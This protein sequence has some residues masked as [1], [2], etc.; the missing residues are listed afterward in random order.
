MIFRI[1]LGSAL[2]IF[3]A[4]LVYRFRSIPGAG[5]FVEKGRAFQEKAKFDL[6]VRGGLLNTVF[7]TKLFKAAKLRWLVHFLVVS[8]FVYLLVVHALD[9]VTS[10]LFY[11]YQPGI[12]PFRFL[13][14]LAG[15]F[16]GLG[17]ILFLLRRMNRFRPGNFHINRPGISASLLI[18]ALVGSGFLLESFQIISEP[19]FDEMVADYSELDEENGLMDLKGFWVQE[20]HLV[21]KDTTFKARVFESGSDLNQEYCMDCHDRPDSAFVSTSLAGFV[22]EGGNRLARFRVDKFLY[23]LHAGIALVLLALVP[24]TR[25][26]H[27]IAIPV[28]SSRKR[29]TPQSLEQGG[30]GLDFFSLTACT[31]CRFCSQV[32]NVYP[33]Y[34]ITGNAGILPHVKIEAIRTMAEKGIGDAGTAVLLRS[35]ND[36]CARCGRCGDIC[37]AGIDLVRLWESADSLMEHLGCPDNYTQVFDTP[38]DQ[39]T[40][41]TFPSQEPDTNTF[42]FG[43]ADQVE[44]FENCVQCTICTNACP[45]VAYD[46]D[47]TDLGPHQ[48]MNL[49]RLGKKE[50]ATASPM[51]W[52]CLTCYACQELCPQGIRITDILL[53]LRVQGQ[54]RAEQIKLTRLT[55]QGG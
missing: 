42:C 41:I 9:D 50:M 35:G 29:V 39:W 3:L 4:G 49:L 14:N 27:L 22:R 34:Q 13:R 7:Q 1:L 37:P 25:M 19:R 11:W 10:G 48:V 55:S 20:Y 38:L 17:C 8:G 26:F 6:D 52:N 28:A 2:I 16:V 51:V 44:A 33:N 53:E 5:R 36:D 54:K 21:V 23:W 47:G 32:C 43:L 18:L 12:A 40:G 46:P 24:F 15:V 45:V 31:D 30:E